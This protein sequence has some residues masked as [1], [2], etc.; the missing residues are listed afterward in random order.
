MKTNNLTS[1]CMA[2]IILALLVF[3]GC[4]KDDKKEIT[5]TTIS[6]TN[7]RAVASSSVQI[8]GNITSDGGATLIARGIC[9][10][11]GQLPT[12]AGDTTI[13]GNDT[14]SFVGYIKNLTSNTKYYFR[15]Y[16]TSSV[17]TAYSDVVQIT[18]GNTATDYDGNIYN[19]VVIGNQV[20]MVEN[21][22]TT[23]YL[24]GDP[25]PT[26]SST[27]EWQA[28]TT[29]AYTD[30]KR[31]GF[32]RDIYGG[33]YNWHAVTDSRNLCPEGWHVPTGSDWSILFNNLAGGDVNT[34]LIAAG[35]N[36]DAS[37][38]GATNESGFSAFPSGTYDGFAVSYRINFWTSSEIDGANA[39][40]I[41][42]FNPGFTLSQPNTRSEE[43]YIGCAV[44]CVKD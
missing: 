4:K 37:M 17:G 15:A 44:R 19:T 7:L 18:T 30:F 24:N 39:S 41:F 8:G 36:N 6:T 31:L 32:G 22:K 33:Y 11:T 9:W 23:H 35:Y 10:G 2:I 29:G 12:I 5:L 21:L 34:K 38:G 27:S 20:W 1:I 25:I 42:I 40:C 16:A 14:G 28:L 13:N 26:V 3:S 43:K